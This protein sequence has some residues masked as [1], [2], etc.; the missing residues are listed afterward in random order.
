MVKVEWLGKIGGDNDQ[1]KVERKPQWTSDKRLTSRKTM[2]KA[3]KSLKD[4]NNP[5]NN[6]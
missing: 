3:R 5:F 4:K 2:L 6:W 1:I